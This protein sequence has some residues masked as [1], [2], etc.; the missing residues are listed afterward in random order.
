MII[1]MTQTLLGVQ[2][3]IRTTKFTPDV[4]LSP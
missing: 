3:A 1:F 4:K 2:T